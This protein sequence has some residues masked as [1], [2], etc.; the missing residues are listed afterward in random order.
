[1]NRTPARRARSRSRRPPA[2]CRSS[3]PGSGG[4]STLVGCLKYCPPGVGR[5]SMT[6]TD[7]PASAA[8][9]AAV[10]P[11]AP[12]PITAMSAESAPVASTAP[13]GT[14]SGRSMRWRRIAIGASIFVMQARWFARP[15][16]STR[17]S[18]Q[19]PMPQNRPRGLSK[20]VLRNVVTPLAARTAATVSPRRATNGRPSRV[21]SIRSARAMSTGAARQGAS[22]ETSVISPTLAAGGHRPPSCILSTTRRQG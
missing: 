22:S 14:P 6:S 20:P 12:P 16:T 21:T 1:M 9:Q 18:W 10:S 4:S 2:N 7:A 8:T 13:P 11:A 5:S 17:Q 15:S 19:T 3:R